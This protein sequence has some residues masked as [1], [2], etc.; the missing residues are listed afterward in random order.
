MKYKIM[1]SDGV[2]EV[3]DTKDKADIALEKKR[4]S[5]GK[6]KVSEGIKRSVTIHECHHDDG[7]K[8]INW[9]RFEK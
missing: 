4:K 2:E 9:E 8:C 6:M 1:T 7:G 3:F 5:L